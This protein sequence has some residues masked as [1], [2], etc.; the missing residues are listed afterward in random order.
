MG[1]G[2][3][4]VSRGVVVTFLITWCVGQ[5]HGHEHLRTFLQ[6]PEQGYRHHRVIQCCWLRPTWVCIPTH[7]KLGKQFRFGETSLFA[8]S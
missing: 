7:M 2:G 6:T 3:G 5:Q 4:T 1:D 8:T